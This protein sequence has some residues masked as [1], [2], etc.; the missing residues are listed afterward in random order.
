MNEQISRGATESRARSGTYHFLS[1]VFLHPP[2]EALLQKLSEL[3]FLKEL[4]Y[5]VDSETVEALRAYLAELDQEQ[6]VRLRQ[7][8]CDLFVVPTERYVAPFE[9]VYQAATPGAQFEKGPLM[10][11][12]AISVIRA[13]R[14]AGAAMNRDCKELPT[15]AG[16]ELGFMGFLC[17]K[18]TEAW[19]RQ[20]DPMTSAD[21]PQL[22]GQ[23]NEYRE[24]QRAFLQ[25]HLAVWLPQLRC[26]IEANALTPYFSVMAEMAAQYVARDLAGLS[27]SNDM[28]ERQIPEMAYG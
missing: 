4:G 8:Y 11:A 27:A 16:V 5:L 22:H 9:D 21:D 24:L 6:L 3:I 2:D 25:R 14:A 20:P 18:E 12:R 1:T 10:G 7:E 13:Y 26:E 19:N 28:L 17:E 15:H 23:V